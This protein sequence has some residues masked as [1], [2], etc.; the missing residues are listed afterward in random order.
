MGWPQQK[1]SALTVFQAKEIVAIFFLAT[2]QLVNVAGEHCGK[3]N[4]L[5]SHGIHLVAHDGFDFAQHSPAK[6]KPCVTAWGGT[7][8]I[9]SAHQQTVAWDLG[10]GRIITKGANEESGGTEHRSKTLL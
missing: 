8:D 4:F 5:C 1:V 3:V 10:I 9:A 7:A 6:G 2:R